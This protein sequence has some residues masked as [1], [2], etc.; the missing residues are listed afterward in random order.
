MWYVFF[1]L[2]AATAFLAIDTARRVRNMVSPEPAM[3]R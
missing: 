1:A 2:I 3:A